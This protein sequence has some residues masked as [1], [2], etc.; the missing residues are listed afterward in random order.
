[1]GKPMLPLSGAVAASPDSD[2]EDNVPVS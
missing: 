1:M 2:H